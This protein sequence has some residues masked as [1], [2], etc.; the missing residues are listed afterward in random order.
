MLIGA[1]FDI[2]VFMQKENKRITGE[3]RKKNTI[4]FQTA[5]IMYFKNLQGITSTLVGIISLVAPS[6]YAFLSNQPVIVTYFSLLEKL[7]LLPI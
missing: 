3:G 5:S 2:N 7:V 6:V 4:N 1:Y